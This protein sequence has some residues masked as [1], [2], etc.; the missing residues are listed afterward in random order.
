MVL[1]NAKFMRSVFALLAVS[2][3]SW[4]GCQKDDDTPPTNET[5]L[6]T[7][8]ILNFTAPGGSVSSFKFSDTD[9]I[10]GNPPVAEDITLAANTT[11]QLDIEFKDESNAS[12]VKDITKEVR[13][14]AEK[15]L[16]CFAASG[17]LDIPVTLDTDADGA[18]LGLETEL[19]T[20]QAGNGTLTIVLKHEPD[21]GAA[22]PCN[23]GETDVQAEF[24]VVVQ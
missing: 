18:P 1:M 9:G 5:E 23:T 16:I 2:A 11:Y 7:T 21:K 3:L 10:G 19:T 12:D 17:V 14:E 15:H 4:A 24:D 8:V 20:G 22:N 13:E 6:I